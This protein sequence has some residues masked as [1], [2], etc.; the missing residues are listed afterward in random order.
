MKSYTLSIAA[1]TRGVKE[2]NI[3]ATHSLIQSMED[4]ARAVQFDHVSGLFTND[5]RSNGNFIQA[6][7]L[8]M[9]CD[10]CHTDNP[11]L[12]LNPAKLAE[13]LHDVEFAVIYSKSHMK[14][15]QDSG[16]IRSARPRFHVYFPL[17]ESVTQ[18][19]TIRELKEA[20]LVVVPEFDDNAK[21]AARFFF[22]VAMPQQEYQE[23]TLCVDEFILIN[24]IEPNTEHEQIE[25]GDTLAESDTEHDSAEL[26]GGLNGTQEGKRIPQGKRNDYLFHVAIEALSL[27]G[28]EKARKIFD[29]A[30]ERCEP[31]LSVK[32]CNTIWKSA[33]KRANAFREKYA[34]KKTTLILSVIEDTLKS[35]NISVRFN[36]IT[37]RLEVSDLPEKSVYLPKEYS[38]MNSRDKQQANVIYLPLFLEGYFRD[39]HFAFSK[40]FLCN[41]IEFIADSHRYNPVLDMLNNTQWDGQDRLSKLC[42]VLHLDNGS[43]CVFLR[44]WLHQAIAIALNDDAMIGPE[45]A[46]TLQGAQGIGKTNFFRKLAM[47]P[48]FF[49]EGAVIDMR[50]K[51][52]IIQATSAWI[53]ELG[54]LDSTLKKEQSNLK[55]FITAHIDTYRR[56]YAR[57]AEQRERR[58]VF[59]ATVNPEPVNRDTTGSRRFVYMHIDSIDKDF[60][61]NSMTPEWVAQLWRQAYEELY[62]ALGRDG[63]H[64]TDEEIAYIEKNNEKFSVPL[65]LETELNDLLKWEDPYT[66][67]DYFTATQIL[68]M[69]EMPTR[70]AAKAG[71]ALQQIIKRYSGANFRRSN[72]RNEYF[73]P[74]RIRKEKRKLDNE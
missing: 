29:L 73:V 35:M 37:K 56:P 70:D 62:L 30:C 61:Y 51:D 6:D 63:Y 69:C 12:W 11:D 23:G 13:R 38:S 16:V 4:L 60:L 17:S 8:M 43:Y 47:I 18:A 1:G 36:V 41:S 57:T 50:N 5:K 10:N 20:L 2:N 44:K 59:C 28:V 54:E 25:L 15:K 72:G 68:K 65:P 42:E 55:G 31:P 24:G 58:T 64:L 21:D 34:E 40:D 53:C 26:D 39:N 71:R 67:W 14:D 33:V 3:Y 7:C 48:D 46:I 27:H 49:C 45:F 19:A 52:T 22:G 74:S 66:E 9:D 32:E